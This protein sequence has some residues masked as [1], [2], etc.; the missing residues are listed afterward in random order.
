M[1][2]VFI[3]ALISD[4]ATR[5]YDHRYMRSTLMTLG[6]AVVFIRLFDERFYN[7]KQSQYSLEARLSSSL[8]G[9]L[10]MLLSG[11]LFF[12]ALARRKHSDR[13][14]SDQR[15]VL[16]VSQIGLHASRI[17]GGPFITAG[18]IVLIVSAVVIAAEVT[19][20]AFILHLE[21]A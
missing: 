13:D 14:F 4:Y 10:F 9:I 20:M 7:S 19:L 8:V 16:P 12:L 2:G 15:K 11:L 6:T 17:F 1:E 5:S 21:I 18:R 3:Y